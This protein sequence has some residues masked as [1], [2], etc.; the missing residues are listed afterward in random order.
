MEVGQ[1]AAAREVRELLASQTRC[2]Q[3]GGQ[4]E[5][6]KPPKNAYHNKQWAAKMKEVGLHPSDTGAKGGAE[7]GRYVSHY[8]VEGGPFAVAFDKFEAR[9]KLELFGDL[10]QP[11]K[12]KVKSSKFKFACPDCDAVCWGKEGLEVSCCACE[13]VMELA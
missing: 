6:G 12:K 3:Q 8:V 2:G 7:T 10:P 9:N 1:R 11:D 5:H 4:E 13:S